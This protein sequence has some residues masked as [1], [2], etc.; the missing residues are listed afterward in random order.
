M[1]AE[2]VAMP[3]FQHSFTLFID[4]H[5]GT[6]GGLVSGIRVL[7]PVVNGWNGMKALAVFITGECEGAEV[8]K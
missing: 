1:S 6:C 2:T 3:S 5:Y 7:V 8:S 4:A